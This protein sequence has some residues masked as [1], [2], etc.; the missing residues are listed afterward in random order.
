MRPHMSRDDE[1]A[2]CRERKRSSSKN[3]RRRKRDA[4]QRDRFRRRSVA[5]PAEIQDHTTLRF[6][7]SFPSTSL[8]FKDFFFMREKKTK[9]KEIF[10]S[11][12][13]VFFLDA[14]NTRESLRTHKAKNKKKG[15]EKGQ[16]K[17]GEKRASF[18][19]KS[20]LSVVLFL[21]FFVLSI[22]FIRDPF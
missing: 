1:N 20:R 15:G 14:T 17:R 9:K 11:F 2:L 10:F 12:F 18:S 5:A 22:F 6:G 21:C 4:R 8:F 19:I 3:E 13:C 16:E 7:A